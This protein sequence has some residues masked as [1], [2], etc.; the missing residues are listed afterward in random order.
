MHI[1]N[2]AESQSQLI[3]K[4]LNERIIMNLMALETHPLITNTS[5]PC[6]A[7]THLIYSPL[8]HALL[9]FLIS[10]LFFLLLSVLHWIKRNLHVISMAAT[11]QSPTL[12]LRYSCSS[13]HALA[14]M[15]QNKALRN[16]SRRGGNTQTKLL[17]FISR[18]QKR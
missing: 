15:F 10:P 4:Q 1:I 6:Q 11:A 14:L 9:A 16:D 12:P 2:I 17:V 3:S 5:S 7:Q 8:P 13:K 18:R